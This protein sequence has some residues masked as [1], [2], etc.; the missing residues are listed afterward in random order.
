MKLKIRD[1]RR[2]IFEKISKNGIFGLEQS[3]CSQ[4]I[5]EITFFSGCKQKFTAILLSYAH[6][7]LIILILN[8]ISPVS[9]VLREWFETK[10]TLT[11]CS[12]DDSRNQKLSKITA[13]NHHCVI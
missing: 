1:Q 12:Y 7:I 8:N 4:N 13:E 6:T 11:V 2:F 10:R 3:V 9:R 5:F